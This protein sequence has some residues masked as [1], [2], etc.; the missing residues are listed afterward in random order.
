MNEYVSRMQSENARPQPPFSRTVIEIESLTVTYGVNMILNGL[1]LEVPAGSI[2]GFLGA[3]GAG[4]TTTIKT[5]LG[6]RPPTSGSVRVLGYDVV[7]QQREMHMHVGYV[8][9]TN[10]FY[11]FLSVSQLC[12][13]SRDMHKHW[14]QGAV[15]HYLQMFE[16]PL[17]KR[18]KHFSKGMKSQ[19]ALCLALGNDPD[20]LILDEPTTELDPVARQVFLTTL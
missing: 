15:D 4:K 1:S 11:D 12:D 5:L 13:L 16:L 7:S 10:S 9:E 3:N 14:N 20:L 2:F 6:F 19:L 18:V 17:N 8:G